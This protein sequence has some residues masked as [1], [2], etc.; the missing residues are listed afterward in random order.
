MQCCLNCGHKMSSKEVQWVLLM[1]VFVHVWGYPTP[2][3]EGE[4]R[5]PHAVVSD[6]NSRL[7]SHTPR[8]KAQEPRLPLPSL[9]E[10]EAIKKVAQILIMLGDQVIPAIIGEPPK[11]LQPPGGVDVPNDPVNDKQD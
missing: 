8:L 7:A 4:P 1:S 2:F 9:Q 10:L 11:H 5:S 6:L 3:R